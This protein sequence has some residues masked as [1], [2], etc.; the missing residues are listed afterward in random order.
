MQ[1]NSLINNIYNICNIT[2]L[3][4]PFTVQINNHTEAKLFDN[5]L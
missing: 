4:L 2:Y 5:K 3:H 1:A